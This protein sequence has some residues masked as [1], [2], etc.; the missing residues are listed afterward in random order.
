MQLVDQQSPT[1]GSVVRTL[2]LVGQGQAAGLGQ[3]T[4]VERQQTHGEHPAQAFHRRPGAM[5]SRTMAAMIGTR[6]FMERPT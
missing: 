2:G 6:C 3:Q 4:G 5:K 1:A